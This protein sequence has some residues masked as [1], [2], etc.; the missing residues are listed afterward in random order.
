LLLAKAVAVLVG[1]EEIGVLNEKFTGAKPAA[2][3]ETKAAGTDTENR[4]P[5]NRRG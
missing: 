3:G 4:R 1:A 5:K 2:A